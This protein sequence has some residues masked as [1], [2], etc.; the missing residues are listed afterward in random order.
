MMDPQQILYSK[1]S[2]FDL[3]KKFIKPNND[4]D[5]GYSV[6]C[7]INISKKIVFTE[8]VLNFLGFAGSTFEEKNA[9]M[10]DLFGC[11]MIPG[12]FVSDQSNSGRKYLMLYCSE[13]EEMIKYLHSPQARYLESLFVLGKIIISKNFE[14]QSIVSSSVFADM[15]SMP[16]KYTS[17]F[18]SSGFCKMSI[19]SGSDSNI[20]SNIRDTITCLQQSFEREQV[21]RCKLQSWQ[22]KQE[23]LMK[24][25]EYKLQKLERDHMHMCK[26]IDLQL[27][28]LNKRLEFSN[29]SQIS[30]DS[31]C[32]I[33]PNRRCA[34]GN[35]VICEFFLF[36]FFI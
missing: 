11:M 1:M 24:N 21:E 22:D 3:C 7:G 8:P 29:V 34:S 23:S 16:I 13:F 10:L 12:R 36:F 27:S 15:S 25:I 9:S 28:Q 20:L 30:V 35:R 6:F 18:E 17:Q 4:K 33:L 2:F 5:G 26:Q 32:S 19:N 31:S 14:L